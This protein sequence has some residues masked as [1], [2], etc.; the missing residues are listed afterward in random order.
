MQIF[1]PIY[2]S[3]GFRV[4]RISV[5]LDFLWLVTALHVMFQFASNKL[6]CVTHGLTMSAVR[7]FLAIVNAHTGRHDEK[8]AIT[9]C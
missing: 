4:G 5:V 9:L 8:P 6:V 2:Q 1:S 7:V 3:I